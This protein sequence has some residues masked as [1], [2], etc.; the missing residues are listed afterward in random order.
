[1]SASWIRRVQICDPEKRHKWE[2]NFDQAV[3]SAEHVRAGQ[4]QLGLVLTKNLTGHL[5]CE[6]VE[7]SAGS[8]LSMALSLQSQNACRR[9][10][11]LSN[12]SAAMGPSSSRRVV[13]ATITTASTSSSTPPKKI[14]AFDRYSVIRSFFRQQNAATQRGGRGLHTQSRGATSA[15]AAA[16]GRSTGNGMWR[17][18]S[19][20]DQSVTLRTGIHARVSLGACRTMQCSCERR[21]DASGSG[22]GPGT[23]STP[24]DSSTQ[25][26][27]DHNQKTNGNAKGDDNSPQPPPPPLP[28][29]HNLENYS[30]FY[31]RLALS[32]PHPHRPTRDDFLNAATG[33]WERLRVRFKWFTIKSF[34]K[35]NADDISAFVTWFVM[36]Q[37]L[38]ILA[39]T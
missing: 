10:L 5:N 21:H 28:P 23:S 12:A 4:G 39:G 20:L 25:P 15:G 35:F 6:L 29:P 2:S 9:G 36:S 24:K 34:R 3:P 19:L 32:L 17:W 38:W 33:F 1:M 30:R 31:R 22:P 37:T 11:L 16:S 26:N 14:E 8:T 7:T 27:D 18:K 13:A